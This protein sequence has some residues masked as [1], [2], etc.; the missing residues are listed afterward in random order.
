M[1]FPQSNSRERLAV[2][3]NNIDGS[4]PATNHVKENG[5]SVGNG[6]MAEGTVH[7]VQEVREAIE[8]L[9]MLD[10]E[11]ESTEEDGYVTPSGTFKGGNAIGSPR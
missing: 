9:T 8:K 4:G 3:E 2:E 10:K 7:Q 1:A 6:E 11:R 5:V